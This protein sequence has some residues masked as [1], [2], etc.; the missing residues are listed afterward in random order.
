[1]SSWLTPDLIKEIKIVF[2]PRYN[3][4]LTSEEIIEISENLT[5]G[6]EQLLKLSVQNSTTS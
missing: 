3:R 5:N 2:E 6:M 1:M 4:L